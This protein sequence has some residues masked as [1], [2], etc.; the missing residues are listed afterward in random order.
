MKKSPSKQRHEAPARL[1]G[2]K[3][4]SIGLSRLRTTT[5]DVDLSRRSKMLDSLSPHD[6]PLDLDPDECDDTTNDDEEYE[7]DDEEDDDDDYMDDD[8]DAVVCE[9]T[10]DCEDE[11]D[12]SLD[13]QL[14]PAQG[15]PPP[16][17]A[18][19]SRGDDAKARGAKQSTFTVARRS[20][21]SGV[22]GMSPRLGHGLGMQRTRASVSYGGAAAAAAVLGSKKSDDR[23]R[24]QA[25]H[26]DSDDEDDERTDDCNET[27]EVRGRL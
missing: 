19:A 25:G 15:F 21:S 27:D 11:A 13:P 14:G 7:E 17:G 20:N 3:M 8:R 9:V 1:S 24:H 5:S 23:I 10:S 18:A 22:D 2:G 16:G 26:E 4:D 12:R 6:E